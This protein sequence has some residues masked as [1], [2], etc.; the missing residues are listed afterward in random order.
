MVLHKWTVITTQTRGNLNWPHMRKD[1]RWF[2]RLVP[3][4]P[5]PTFSGR[6]ERGSWFRRCFWSPSADEWM[7]SVNKLKKNPGMHIWWSVSLAWHLSSL[8]VFLEILL[9]RVSGGVINSIQFLNI[10]GRNYSLTKFPGTLPKLS[11]KW[12]KMT[13]NCANIL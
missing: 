7:F 4:F 8:S 2:Q 12:R 6:V 3:V 13:H 5:D 10:F 9:E 1:S 11:S